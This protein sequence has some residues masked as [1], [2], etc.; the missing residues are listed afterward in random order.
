MVA[1]VASG[2]WGRSNAGSIAD[3]PDGSKL[4][5]STES[6][7]PT[8]S[9]NGEDGSNMKSGFKSLA[10]EMEGID[11]W[12]VTETIESRLP[13]AVTTV[14]VMPPLLLKLPN[15]EE[16]KKERGGVSL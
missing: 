9:V 5:L 7:D 10:R 15:E 12:S 3:L 6:G 2:G 1:S 11:S 4:K 14:T 16:L 13:D 8:E